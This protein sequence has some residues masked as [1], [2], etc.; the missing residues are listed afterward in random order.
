MNINSAANV[1]FFSGNVSKN[2]HVSNV[3]ATTPETTTTE[4]IQGMYIHIF[5]FFFKVFVQT[6]L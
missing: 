3:S 6:S 1:I 4:V 5:Q 2:I